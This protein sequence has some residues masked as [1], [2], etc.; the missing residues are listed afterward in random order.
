MDFINIAH[1][2]LFLISPLIFTFMFSRHIL[3]K[4]NQRKKL[5]WAIPLSLFLGLFAVSVSV[6][7]AN[8]SAVFGF[9]FALIFF[10]YAVTFH[11]IHK[12]PEKELTKTELAKAEIEKYKDIPVTQ[13]PKIPVPKVKEPKKDDV[14]T[15]TEK[16]HNIGK[17]SSSFIAPITKSKG[18][19]NIQFWYTDF[20]GNFTLRNVDVRSLNGEYLEAYCHDK[21]DMR[22]FRVERIDNE[23]IDLSTGE[24]LS[25][26]QWLE[27]HGIYHIVKRNKSYQSNSSYDDF[28][29]E[30]C[31]TGFKKA[32]RERLER[33]AI[34]NDYVVRKSV[35]I[36]LDYLVC[37]SNAG[38]TK[39]AQA[40][41]QG[42]SIIDEEEFL[43]MIGED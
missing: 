41:S 11:K 28:S 13:L 26:E 16:L 43:E 1:P 3:R 39:L 10:I 14:R 7:F 24:V 4:H 22:T 19:E 35:T 30:I 12:T 25:K 34:L 33:L 5:F 23:I 40:E 42:V 20:E 8:E 18:K 27:N 15:E 36:N 21:E 2:A 32:D 9:L 29:E 31:F 37:G 17:N 6:I 38:P